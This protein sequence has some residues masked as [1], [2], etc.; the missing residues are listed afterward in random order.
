M[1]DTLSFPVAL[2]W[3]LKNLKAEIHC[4]IGA[5]KN[6]DEAS[7][8]CGAHFLHKTTSLRGGKK[9]QSAAIGCSFKDAHML[10]CM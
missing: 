7:R 8:A 2:Y 9:L 5:H 3:L 6:V 1:P 4:F 10:I